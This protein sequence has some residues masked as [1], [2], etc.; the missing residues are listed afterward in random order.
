MARSALRI[1]HYPVLNAIYSA[2]AVESCCGCLR[3]RR[4]C[5]NC[6]R[7]LDDRPNRALPRVGFRFRTFS[8]EGI[9]DLLAQRTAALGRVTNGFAS[10]TGVKAWGKSNLRGDAML[11]SG[12]V[13]D[14]IFCAK[15]LDIGQ[16]TN[17]IAMSR[18]AFWLA[19]TGIVVGFRTFSPRRYCGPFRG[20]SSDSARSGVTVLSFAGCAFDDRQGKQVQQLHQWRI[21]IANRHLRSHKRLLV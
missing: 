6:I 15:R 16:L 1:I 20:R 10:Q 13:R 12:A 9:N 2:I 14:P 21:L 8:G 18:A 17:A 3:A 4:P 5:S 7:H 11:T 19:V